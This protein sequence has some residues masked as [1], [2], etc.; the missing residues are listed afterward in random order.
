[1][2]VS[3]QATCSSCGHQQEVT[4]PGGIN[5]A[6]D[7]TLKER[8]KD[9][10]LFV[11]E[12]PVCGTKNLIRSQILY[13]DP[14]M[15]LMVWLLPEGALPEAQ[16]K[17]LEAALAAQA[18]A[19]EGYVLRRVSEVGELIEKV[20]LHDTGLDDRILEMCK[21]VTKMDLAEKDRAHAAVI[22]DAPMKFFRMEGA[23][24]EITLTWP[25]DGQMQ[26]VKIGFNIYEDCRGILQ[27]NPAIQVG[28]G[29]AR[30][31]A[32]WLAKYFR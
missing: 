18:E 26:G 31:D 4:V 17:T 29:F 16:A 24:N 12:C 27:R 1:M 30:V 5:V 13:H 21:Y 32:G 20:N 28:P 22:L 7:P 19:L 10:S 6:E 9:G 11:W 23:D 15:R 25:Q 8:V 2:T 14:E 3:Q